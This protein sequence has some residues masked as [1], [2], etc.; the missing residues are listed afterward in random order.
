M[1]LFPDE[2]WEELLFSQE[3]D[4][5]FERGEPNS[6]TSIVATLLGE[7]YG[8]EAA[9]AFYGMRIGELHYK[10]SPKFNKF[11]SLVDVETLKTGMISVK[12]AQEIWDEI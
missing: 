11:I 6:K 5:I 2:V 8:E 4:D 10:T 1:E 12:R 3:E 7:Y 9:V